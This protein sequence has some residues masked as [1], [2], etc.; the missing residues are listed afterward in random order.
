MYDQTIH[1]LNSSHL[2]LHVWIILNL[3]VIVIHPQRDFV[4]KTTIGRVCQNRNTNASAREAFASLFTRITREQGTKDKIKPVAESN[5]DRS[6]T[7]PRQLVHVMWIQ[8]TWRTQMRLVAMS[9]TFSSEMFW[10]DQIIIAKSSRDQR[11][12]LSFIKLPNRILSSHQHLTETYFHNVFSLVFLPTSPRLLSSVPPP[13]PPAPPP[14]PRPPQAL[15]KL[16][17]Q[18][19][20]PPHTTPKSLT[21][22]LSLS[23]YPGEDDVFLSPLQRSARLR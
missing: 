12:G 7:D 17:L 18:L 2:E 19:P 8:S 16:C 9:W 4:P 21:L 5:P 23:E 20:Q 11:D 14:P 13:P 1:V 10:R 22:S 3:S 6:Q 15:A